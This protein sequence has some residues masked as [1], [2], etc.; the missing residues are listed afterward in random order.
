MPSKLN[1]MPRKFIIFSFLLK[2]VVILIFHGLYQEY[3]NN[4][5]ILFGF[6]RS[7]D[8]GINV[9]PIDNLVETGTYGIGDGSKPYTGR[10][11]AMI[12]PYVI[13][14]FFFDKPIALG[15]QG[16]FQIILSLIS[17]VCLFQII[18]KM[19][20]KIKDWFFYFLIILYVL[21]SPF[22]HWDIQLNPE[23]LSVSSFIFS[24]Y[25]LQRRKTNLDILI[26][27]LFLTWCFFLRGFL[28]VYFIV[29][30]LYILWTVRINGDG[31][32]PRLKTV[33]I[34][35][36]PFMIFEGAW[37]SRNFVC[38]SEFIPLQSSLSDEADAYEGNV[39]YKQ[40]MLRARKLM[41]AMGGE[42]IHYYP[43]AHMNF[44]YPESEA[45]ALRFLPQIAIKDSSFTLSLFELRSNILA[46]R[47][48]GNPVLEKRII[49]LS[50][51]LRSQFIKQ[52]SF[53]FY[54]IKPFLSIRNFFTFNVS[55]DWPGL[56]FR[57]S[58][59]IIK[60]WKLSNVLCYYGLILL[61]F[62]SVFFKFQ[63]PHSNIKYW[64][65][66]FWSCLFL[67]L[68]PFMFYFDTA[69]YKYFFTSYVSLFIILS[70]KTSILIEDF[71]IAGKNV[72]RT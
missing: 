18:Y 70:M 24:L 20:P 72:N 14:T 60:I 19:I 67:F 22:N 48:S 41:H 69:E 16:I 47:E 5:E 15:I 43:N 8:E 3:A 62:I 55:S 49:V 31:V 71:S 42:T 38:C 54:F 13:F 50:D 56:S 25:F 2:A 7:N 40:S 35:L 66:F 59:S 33:F 6:P 52:N 58:P 37:I 32:L 12:F 10:T 29:F 39:H 68:I 57:D 1:L 51:S 65:Y 61:S 64:N 11:P 21:G 46:A 28:G 63:H 4:S 27:G 45:S 53:F 17:T 26:S 9:I 30:V 34:F 44:F 23:S 36:I